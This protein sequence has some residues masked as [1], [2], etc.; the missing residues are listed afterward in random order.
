MDSDIKK[1]VKKQN[2]LQEQIN[3]LFAEKQILESTI[4]VL[5]ECLSIEKVRQKI[6]DL[7][8]KQK[9]LSS[10]ESMIN[11]LKTDIKPLEYLKQILQKQLSLQ[12]ADYSKINDTKDL[13]C[14]QISTNS[15]C[16]IETLDNFSEVC[17]EGSIMVLSEYDVLSDEEVLD[18]SEKSNKVMYDEALLMATSM[19]S[20]SVEPSITISHS[21]ES[22]PN[23]I[24][25]M[26]DVNSLVQSNSK[27]SSILM[28]TSHMNEQLLNMCGELNC[29]GN[30]LTYFLN[31]I[32][33]KN[34]IL[35]GVNNFSF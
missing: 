11:K 26:N 10:L 1:Y 6:S 9:I 14:S 21:I 17:S 22:L 29:D 16:A 31:I 7:E 20:I 27:D 30:V 23:V 5:S 33:I 32:L 25:K 15:G 19:H 18:S 12:S 35:F 3:E 8:N 34:I 13:E 24:D 28:N 4:S 2:Q